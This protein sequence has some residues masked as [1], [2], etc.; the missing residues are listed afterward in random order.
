MMVR[1]HSEN[2]DNT[3]DDHVLPEDALLNAPPEE[4]PPKLLMINASAFSIDPPESGSS[5]SDEA[6]CE[7]L[8]LE[9]AKHIQMARSQQALYQN[10]VAAA[11][12]NAAEGK[13][14]LFGSIFI[15]RI[16]THSL[17]WKVRH[18]PSIRCQLWPQHG[19]PGLY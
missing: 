14:M 3:I 4:E 10:H 6:S 11:I 7:L 16:L 15:V 17:F 5:K 8:L 18:T 9:S 19:T 2:E 1:D 12:Y 13:F